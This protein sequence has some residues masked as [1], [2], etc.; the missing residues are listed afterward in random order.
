MPSGSTKLL[1]VGLI[2]GGT[3][4]MY[5]EADGSVTATNFNGTL[6]GSVNG[7]TVTAS[8]LTVNGSSQFNGGVVGSGNATFAS[9]TVTAQNFVG[10]FG[11]MTIGG[12]G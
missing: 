7:G 8:Q 1:Q 11:T 2:S 5:V 12:S 10:N 4:L 9:G 6:N 3:P